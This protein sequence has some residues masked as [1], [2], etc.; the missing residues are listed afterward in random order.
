[1]EYVTIERKITD[2]IDKISINQ[3][4]IANELQLKII[5]LIFKQNIE[6]ININFINNILKSNEQEVQNAIDFWVENGFLYVDKSQKNINI[7][8][9]LDNNSQKQEIIN[10]KKEFQGNYISE[11][12][13]KSESI[14]IFL[15]E[16][17][18]ILGRPL[19]GGDITT[20]LN[21][22]D[23]EGIS[24]EVILMIIQYCV[25]HEK[26]GT[27]YIQKV[28]IDWIKSGIDSIEKIEQKIKEISE[29]NIYWKKFE[30]I[31]G[32]EQRAPSS[33]EKEAVLRWFK[34]WNYNEEMVKTAYEICVN[35]KNKYILNYIDS[36]I[37]RWRK[38]KI[39]NSNDLQLNVKNISQQNI[40]DMSS[41]ELDEY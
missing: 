37:T 19:S 18:N 4:K 13:K 27:R 5:I 31:T 11:R 23:K 40:K 14:T 3:I 2:F 35:L 21:L 36:I 9:N 29:F 33:K 30:R 12:I 17:Q 32:I 41:Y 28:A 7:K 34:T 10:I 24:E 25:E 6:K 39:N 26:F 8:E 15:N 38:D 20:F 1:M 22:K 16:A